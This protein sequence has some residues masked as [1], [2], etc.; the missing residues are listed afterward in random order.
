M[1]WVL[2]VDDEATNLKTADR[3]LS[4]SGIRVTALESGQ[5]MLDF[6]KENAPS[7]PDLILLD[8]MM[9]GMDGFETLAKL[10]QQEGDG[11][12]TPV[13]FLSADQKLATESRGLRSGA[14]DYIRKPLAP[15]ILITRVQNALRTQERSRTPAARRPAFCACWTW[16]IL[17]SSTTSAATI[18][19]TAP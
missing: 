12:E 13:I 17:S 7:T 5:A 3:V 2:I 11:P 8:T 14:V 18:W 10:R 19:A 6:L 9:P 16:T 15:G 1:E 4:R